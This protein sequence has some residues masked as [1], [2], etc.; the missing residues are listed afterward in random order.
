MCKRY[1]RGRPLSQ[2]GKKQG[3]S[4][5][6]KAMLGQS[7]QIAKCAILGSQ[8]VKTWI[9]KGH[10]CSVKNVRATLASDLP[11]DEL[12][13][14]IWANKIGKVAL[15]LRRIRGRSLPTK[16]RLIRR[17]MS[18]GGNC[19]LCTA[20]QESIDHLFSSCEYTRWVLAE[21]MGAAGGFVK[22]D[23]ITNFKESAN[24]LNKVTRGTRHGVCYGI[25]MEFH[26]S[27]SESRGIRGI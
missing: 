3:D 22:L 20:G 5:N 13:K 4:G 7:D 24:E 21:A 25:F 6:R 16:D 10:R 2:I 9:G 27:T 23:T 12:A 14:G 1:V 17:G 18:I 26:P 15:N 11:I 8:Y 19:E